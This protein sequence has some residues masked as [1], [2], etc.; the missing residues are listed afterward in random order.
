MLLH[1]PETFLTHSPPRKILYF[2]KQAAISPSRDLGCSR[3]A[4]IRS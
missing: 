3:F 4:V 1:A 2:S